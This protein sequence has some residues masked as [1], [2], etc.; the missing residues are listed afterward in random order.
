MAR[1]SLNGDLIRTEAVSPGMYSFLS[2]TSSIMWSSRRDHVLRPSPLMQNSFFVTATRPLESL[3]LVALEQ[4]DRAAARRAL[5]EYVR[6]GGDDVA[7]A[8][9][10]LGSLDDTP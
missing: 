6:R 2:G 4:E 9:E 10:T 3:A 8:E 5:R 7:W 1:A